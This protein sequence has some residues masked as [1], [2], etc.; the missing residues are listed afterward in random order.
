LGGR[1]ARSKIRV[2]DWR[3]RSRSI[4]TILLGFYRREKRGEVQRSTEPGRGSL[5]STDVEGGLRGGTLGFQG[6][7]TY[8]RMRMNVHDRDSRWVGSSRRLAWQYRPRRGNTPLLE[9]RSDEKRGGRK[10]LFI[11]LRDVGI[12]AVN[13]DLGDRSFMMSSEKRGESRTENR[14][15]SSTTKKPDEWRST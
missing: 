9:S 12:G 11:R 6:N 13:K 5:P 8:A 7:I 1:I 2:V 14:E 4:E 3:L 15:K 10:A